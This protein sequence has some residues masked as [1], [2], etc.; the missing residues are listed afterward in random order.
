MGQ[1]NPVDP[2]Q[3]NDDYIDWSDT[4]GTSWNPWFSGTRNQSVSIDFGCHSPVP[5][6]HVYKLP[7]EL[8]LVLDGTAKSKRKP[9][10][11]RSRPS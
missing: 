6:G 2:F 3:V 5:N 8:V 10:H 11:G 4:K 9:T 7:Y 1:Q